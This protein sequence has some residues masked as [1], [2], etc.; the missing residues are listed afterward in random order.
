MQ[1][2]IFDSVKKKKVLFEPIHPGNSNESN[3][4]QVIGIAPFPLILLT[5]P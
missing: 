2:Q 1:M 3:E 4:S 5:I